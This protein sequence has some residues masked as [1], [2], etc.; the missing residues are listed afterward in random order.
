MSAVIISSTAAVLAAQAS[1]N[2]NAARV[3]NCKTLVQ[4]FDSNTATVEQAQGYADCVDL[5]YPRHQEMPA[6]DI[7]VLKG[8]IVLALIGLIAG[9]RCTWSLGGG[10]G[11]RIAYSA[12]GGILGAI[13]GPMAAGLLVLL[14]K[15][16]LFLFQG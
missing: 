9:A 6:G 5:L 15:A 13:T 11:D 10:L 12:L 4:G 8:V 1:A 16:V 3:T 7:L 14:V 2:A